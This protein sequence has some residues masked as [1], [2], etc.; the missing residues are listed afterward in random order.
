[1]ITAA[2]L[3]SYGGEFELTELELAPPGPGEVLV[4]ITATGFCHTDEKVRQGAR[5]V[6][7]PVV[8]GH[9]GAGRVEA[10]GPGVGD[11]RTGDH[12]VLTFAHCGGCGNCASGHPAYCERMDELSF[13][14]SVRPLRAADHGLVRGGFFGQSSFAT[15]AVVDQ[16]SAVRVDP[17]LPLELLGPLGC[18]IQ[19]GAGSILN[20]L[21]PDAEASLA[22]WGV[23]AVGLSAV[24]AAAW[25]GVGT[26]IAIDV[27]PNRLALAGELG[28]THTVLADA[29]GSSLD[30]LRA[31]APAGVSHA[32]DTSGRADVL[33]E[34]VSGLAPRGRAGFVGGARAGEV[35]SL[36]I[37]RLL[38][39][40]S[41]RGII[42]GDA[43]PQR[44]IPALAE[45]VR[46]GQLPLPRLVTRY[47]LEEIN[48]AAAD[49]A[50]GRTVKPVLTMPTD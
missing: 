44:L 41:L 32:L 42:Q 17:E 19:T 18:S 16:R 20:V 22:V 10:V 39:G 5:S 50:C 49:A 4:R 11:L 3:R 31:L 27:H 9:E 48:L 34:M 35:V 29:A 23:G 21:R 14:A 6:P 46:N 25:S 26:I 8:L 13:G 7:L 2:V 30:G 24:A 37:D 45:R 47:P 28:A 36:E 43:M 1:M 38:A 15:H 33:C 12:V 40:R